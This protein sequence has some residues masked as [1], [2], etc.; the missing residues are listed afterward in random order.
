MHSLTAASALPPQRALHSL[1]GALSAA[2]I[3]RY[4]LADL[5][6]ARISAGIIAA[7]LTLARRA[8]PI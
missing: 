6:E 3:R 2:T 1:H 4:S 8:V 5:K 7:D